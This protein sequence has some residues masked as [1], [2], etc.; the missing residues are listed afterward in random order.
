[1]FSSPV[2]AQASGDAAAPAGGGLMGFLPIILIVVIFWFLVIRPQ[3]KRMKEHRRMV[4]A[5]Q[6]GDTVVTGGGLVGKVARVKDD[7]ELEVDLADGVRVR[8]I[9]ST[10]QDVRS[11]SEP[12][13]ADNKKDDDKDEKSAS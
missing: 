6:R 3:S 12:A 7:G 1:M 8:V 11:K 9:R 13:P 2:L 4:E 5:V 10:L